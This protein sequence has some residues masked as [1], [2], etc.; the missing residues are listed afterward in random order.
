MKNGSECFET[1]VKK[2]DAKETEQDRAQRRLSYT[3]LYPKG[4]GSHLGRPDGN[5]NMKRASR[6]RTVQKRERTGARG[7]SI[8]VAEH[9]CAS[10]AVAGMIGTSPYR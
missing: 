7:N 8:F 6:I 5:N 9:V 4:R 10:G 1:E 3:Y 2:C